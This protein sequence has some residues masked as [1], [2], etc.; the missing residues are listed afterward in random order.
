VNNNA[1]SAGEIDRVTSLNFG[2]PGMTTD[3]GYSQ[4]GN[5][6]TPTTSDRSS[7]TGSTVGFGGFSSGIQP[8]QSSAT[9]IIRTNATNFANNGATNLIDG[10]IASV[11]TFSPTPEPATLVLAGVGVPVASLLGFLRRRRSQPA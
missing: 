7:G 10:G 1:G 5:Q 4:T 2:F 3:V 9:L 11:V 6:L 8:G